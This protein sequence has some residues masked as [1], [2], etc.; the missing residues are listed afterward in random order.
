M[1][2]N[3]PLHSCSSQQ[4]RATSRWHSMHAARI[5]DLARVS[6]GGSANP[7]LAHTAIKQPHILD[8]KYTLVSM[9]VVKCPELQG[10][11]ESLETTIPRC[12]RARIIR[13]GLERAIWARGAGRL[14]RR[15]PMPRR[16]RRLLGGPAASHAF[17]YSSRDICTATGQLLDDAR[18]CPSPQR[19]HRGDAGLQAP[20][21]RAERRGLGSY[22][23]SG[24]M[25]GRSLCSLQ[26][27]RP[28]GPDCR[29]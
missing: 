28:S 19:D 9:C 27:E 13:P 2:D 4:A 5:T 25:E 18:T 21:Y 3:P 17:A 11:R 12:L 10:T 22:V 8:K 15:P 24:A 16:D 14:S 1:C 6:Q 20:A 29:L 23:R 7:S 26:Q